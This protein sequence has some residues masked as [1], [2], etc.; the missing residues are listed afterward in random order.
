MIHHIHIWRHW[1][2]AFHNWHWLHIDIRSP[3]MMSIYHLY[4]TY[5]IAG[6]TMAYAIAAALRLRPTRRHAYINRE[7]RP[8]AK[9]PIPD[10]SVG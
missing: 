8:K 2:L 6:I 10:R 7:E 3:I 5:I 4:G 1:Y 9:Q